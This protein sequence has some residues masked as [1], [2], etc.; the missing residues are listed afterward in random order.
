[1]SIPVALDDLRAAV[2]ERGGAAYLLTVSDAG[3]P[4][5]VHVAVA[6]DG[7]RLAADV[8]KRTA[9]NAAARSQVSL[10][11]PV[12][13]GGDYSLIVDGTAA[14]DGRRVLVTPTHAI[15][16]RAATGAAPAARATSCDADCAPLV[17]TVTTR[18][19]GG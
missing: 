13:D 6:W 12:R 19:Q 16:H 9:A 4:H 7:D 5:A 10:L 3:A 14:V 17:G 11:W 15:L 18:P 8:G 1:M 2:A